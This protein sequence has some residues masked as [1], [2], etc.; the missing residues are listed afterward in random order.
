MKSDVSWSMSA[1]FNIMIISRRLHEAINNIEVIILCLWPLLEE[2]AY[3]M[4]AR[5]LA[6]SPC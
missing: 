6:K 4:R 3:F 1:M 2:A 5:V